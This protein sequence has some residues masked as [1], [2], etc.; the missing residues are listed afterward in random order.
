MQSGA[1]GEIISRTLPSRKANTYKF[2][3]PA[4]MSQKNNVERLSYCSVHHK[5]E[6]FAVANDLNKELKYHQ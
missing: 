1:N 4:G 2:Y 5:S 3:L 6:N